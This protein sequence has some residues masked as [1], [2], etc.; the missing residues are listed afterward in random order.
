M[1]FKNID[2]NNIEKL[3]V[4]KIKQYLNSLEVGKLY[5]VLPI[6]KNKLGQNKTMSSSI[7]VSKGTDPI[8]L[9][10][11]LLWDKMNVQALY[12]SEY[13]DKDDVIL[14]L[15]TKVW[16]SENEYKDNIETVRK[17]LDEEVKKGKRGV[18]ITNGSIE[19]IKVLKKMIQLTQFG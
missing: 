2:I 10:E 19:N 7:K 14:Y 5:T 1:N 8:L 3:M 17:V 4:D 6:L 12:S 18:K 16:L 13:E 9:A 11:R 15:M